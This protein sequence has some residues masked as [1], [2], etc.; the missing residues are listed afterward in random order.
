MADV[1]HANPE[2]LQRLQR[3]IE[4]ARREIEEALK[5]LQRALD[6]ADW[7]DPRRDEFET[8][9]KEASSTVSRTTSKLDELRPILSRE[10]DALNRYLQRG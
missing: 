5:K 6:Q 3:A 4:Q 1:V 10:I 9:M 7:K 8:K 2:H